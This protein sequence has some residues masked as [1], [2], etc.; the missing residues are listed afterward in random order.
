MADDPPTDFEHF[1]GGPLWDAN[2]TWYT[3]NP[4][5]TPCFHRT[6][7]AWIPAG[8]LLLLAPFSFRHTFGSNSRKIRFNIYNLTKILCTMMAIGAAVARIANLATSDRDDIVDAEWVAPAVAIGSYLISMTLLLQSMY[9]GMMSSATQWLFYGT[10]V[11]CNA[12]S[13]RTL[14]QM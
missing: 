12:F 1:C 13:L 14:M 11:I 4:D 3:N 6:V 8:V 9:F 7:L 5:F 2:V 10:A